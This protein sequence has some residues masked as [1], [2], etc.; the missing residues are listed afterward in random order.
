MFIW[1]YREDNFEYWIMQYTCERRDMED[2][3]TNYMD[4]VYK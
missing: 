1:Y 4:D 2:R 3:E